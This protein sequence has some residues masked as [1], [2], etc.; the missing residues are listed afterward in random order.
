MLDKDGK[1][2]REGFYSDEERRMYVVHEKSG[3]FV[4]DTTGGRC[5]FV[6]QE[7]AEHANR[8]RGKPI[9]SQTLR[10]YSGP[11]LLTIQYWLRDESTRLAKE[12][13]FILL[14]RIDHPSLAF[15][16]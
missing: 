12:L 14:Q 6:G 10:R 1:E 16:E 4:A 13:D 8:T 15:Q 2:I 11:E 3:E 7:G 5:V 9:D